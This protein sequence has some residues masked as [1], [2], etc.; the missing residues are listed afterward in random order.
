MSRRLGFGI[1]Y[2]QLR[3][4]YGEVV[5]GAGRNQVVG[6]QE[7]CV[8][9]GLLR[10]RL[11]AADRWAWDAVGGAGVTFQHHESGWCVPPKPLCEIDTGRSTL[12]RRAPVFALGSEVPIRIV[13][14]IAIVPAVRAYSL[15][16]VVLRGD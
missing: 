4:V 16:A 3:L 1:E 2:A 9:V 7:E 10:V 6:R 5:T 13:R 12:D 15:L 8:L 11:W 14:N